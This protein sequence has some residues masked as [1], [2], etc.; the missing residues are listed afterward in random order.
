MT[1]PVNLTDDGAG[2]PVTAV[3]GRAGTGGTAGPGTPGGSAAPPLSGGFIP[4][5]DEAAAKAAEIKKLLESG[6]VK[7]PITPTTPGLI[8]DASGGKGLG[9]TPPA[10]PPLQGGT[11]ANKQLLD[12]WHVD[13]TRG[14]ARE[15]FPPSGPTPRSK[16]V[17]SYTIARDGTLVDARISAF[18]GSSAHDQA[19]LKAVRTYFVSGRGKLPDAVT[20]ATH[21]S[22][23]TVNFGGTGGPQFEKGDTANR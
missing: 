20:D 5:S 11:A 10:A 9:N 17:I 18:S 15:Y 16:T 6:Q 2:G 8:A 23:I 19:V 14:L 21:A 22:S 3:T 1:P 7:A 13:T 4:G 12:A